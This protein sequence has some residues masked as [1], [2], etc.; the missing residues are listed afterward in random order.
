MVSTKRELELAKRRKVKAKLMELAPTDSA[1]RKLCPQCGKLTDMKD[2][3][4]KLHLCHDGTGASRP[5]TTFKTCY[6]ACRACHFGEDGHRTENIEHGKFGDRP[7]ELAGF[8]K[9]HA[10]SKAVQTGISKKK[11]K[12]VRNE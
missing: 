10:Y 2:G 3:V 1:G 7:I 9:G 5:K 8:H 12:D 4:G 6:L 11:V